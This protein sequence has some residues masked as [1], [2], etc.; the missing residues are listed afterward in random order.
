MPYALNLTLNGAS[1]LEIERLYARLSRLDVPEHDLVTQYGPCIT[2][3]V[4][5]DRVTPRGISRLLEWKLQTLS[6]LAVTFAMTCVTHGRPPTL[7]LRVEA[8]GA[9]LELHD[10]IYRELPEE[11]VN[12]HYRPAYWQPHLKL[13]NVRDEQAGARLAAALMPHWTPFGGTIDG[14][15]VVQYPP[16]QS[17]WQ[18]TLRTSK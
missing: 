14:L 8:S 7:G 1:R 10:A 9:L 2:L 12:I 17:I 13:S 5:T 16:V 18:A 11:E 6:T 15:E 3:L 4:L